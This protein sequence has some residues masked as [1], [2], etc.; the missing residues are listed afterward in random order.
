MTCTGGNYLGLTL[1]L[2]KFNSENQHLV[3]KG[4]LVIFDYNTSLSFKGF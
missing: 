1:G 4:D 2:C 3:I